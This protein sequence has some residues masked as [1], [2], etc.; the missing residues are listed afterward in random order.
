MMG[1]VLGDKKPADFEKFFKD[2]LNVNIKFAEEVK[3]LPDMDPTGQPVPETDGRND[4]L[5]W[6]NDDDIS[7]FAIARLQYGIRWW[8]D[9]VKYNNHAAWYSKEI[10]EKYPVKW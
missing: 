5:F 9:V 2:E 4:I 1:C 6:I 10:L 7:K 8:E 3:T